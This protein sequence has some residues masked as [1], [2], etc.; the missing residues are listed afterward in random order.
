MNKFDE[1]VEYKETFISKIKNVF[2]RFFKRVVEE[3][4][5]VIEIPCE[6]NQDIQ[7][8]SFM[9]EIR[10]DDAQIDKT[11]TKEE[12]LEKINGNKEALKLLSIDRLKKL[13]QYYD[14][15]IN[16]NEKKIK[17]LEGSL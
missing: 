9:D 14:E 6:K 1:M 11:L 8:K 2:K 10:V 5:E 4:N 13:N 3:K 15:I 16:K 12:F 17:K 7:S